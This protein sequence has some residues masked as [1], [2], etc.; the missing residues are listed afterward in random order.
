[1]SLYCRR[2]EEVITIPDTKKVYFVDILNEDTDKV[3]GYSDLKFDTMYDV[4]N[5]VLNRDY[6]DQF[7]VTDLE[8]VSLLARA[9]KEGIYVQEEIELK[10]PS[11]ANGTEPSDFTG[12]IMCIEGPA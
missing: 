2:Q 6:R 11:R 7:G 5:N 10:F 3:P 8:T 12:Y 9:G 4:L 1:V